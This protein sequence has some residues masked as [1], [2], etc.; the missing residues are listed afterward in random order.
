MDEFLKSSEWAGL[1]ES[2]KVLDVTLSIEK[3][4]FICIN[5]YTP[6]GHSHHSMLPKWE[7]FDKYYWVPIILKFMDA[8]AGTSIPKN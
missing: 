8:M 3:S 5:K 6:A 2:A 4:G 7:A 1:Q